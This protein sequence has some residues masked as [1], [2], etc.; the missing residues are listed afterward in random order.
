MKE[1]VVEIMSYEFAIDIVKLCKRLKELKE[2]EFNNQL[3]RSSTSIGA[4][5]AEAETSFSKREF[6]YKLS[7]SIRETRETKYWLRLIRDCDIIEEST[8]N[9]YIAKAESIEKVLSSII[10]TTKKRYNL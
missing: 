1:S 5:I 8:I 4:N 3:F 9:E 6:V 10:I 2:Y 7:I